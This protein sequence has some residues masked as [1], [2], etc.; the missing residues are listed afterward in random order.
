MIAIRGG[1]HRGFRRGS[2]AVGVVLEDTLAFSQA[3]EE[4][5]LPNLVRDFEVAPAD[6]A[7]VRL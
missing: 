7:R 2:Y 4:R 6:L 1:K 3:A 5:V